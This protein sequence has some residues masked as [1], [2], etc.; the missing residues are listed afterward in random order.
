MAPQK[1]LE[2]V[3]MTNPP[4]DSSVATEAGASATGFDDLYQRE[5]PKIAALG[6][7]L[8][9]SWSTAE[10]LAQD[11]FLDAY[12]GWDRIGKLDRPGAWVRR[13]VINRAA[14]HGRHAS[15]ERRG[16]HVVATP[17]AE[18]ANADRTGDGATDRLGDPAF[19]AAVRSLPERQLAAVALHYL[20]DRSVADIAGVLDCRPATVKVHLH[21]GR[22]TLARLLQALAEPDAP[23]GAS[24]R[25]TSNTGKDER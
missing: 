22:R 14:S 21:R 8:T 25:T 7:S 1:R 12:R 9:G 10:E 20:E 4:P 3:P 11:A 19:W 17:G 24:D 18:P 13:A 2:E 23:A 6:W 5:W 15:V 16:L